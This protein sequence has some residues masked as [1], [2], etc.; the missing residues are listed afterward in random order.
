MNLPEQRNSPTNSLTPSEAKLV[1]NELD[2]KS[3]ESNTS[4][5]YACDIAHGEAG[6]LSTLI[7]LL[8]ASEPSRGLTDEA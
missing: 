3:N 5:H 2:T 6:L 8:F 4:R 1:K 7:D